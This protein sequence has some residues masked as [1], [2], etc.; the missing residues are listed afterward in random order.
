M[1]TQDSKEMNKQEVEVMTFYKNTV[2]IDQGEKQVYVY[3][4][5]MEEWR[6]FTKGLAE[7]VFYKAFQAFCLGILIGLFTGFFT[8]RADVVQ[9]RKE[10]LIQAKSLD[11]AASLMAIAYIESSFQPNAVGGA[12][13]QGLFQFHPKYFKLKDK[14]IKGQI[15]FAIN[16]MEYLTKYCPDVSLSLAWNLG[17]SKAKRLKKPKEFTYYVKYRKYKTKFK[18]ELVGS[19]ALQLFNIRRSLANISCT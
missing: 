18:T 12:K 16:H 3:T 17:C 11:Q 14:S 4:E 9:V 19:E 8:A 10:V 1:D 6:A 5:T 15:R 7:L 2:G 13:E